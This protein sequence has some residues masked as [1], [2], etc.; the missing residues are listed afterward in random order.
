MSTVRKKDFSQTG[1]LKPGRT[2]FNLSYIKQFDCDMGQL[3]PIM[4][5]E[6]IPGDKISVGNEMNHT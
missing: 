5:D 1:G 6:V 3:I 2:K 4:C